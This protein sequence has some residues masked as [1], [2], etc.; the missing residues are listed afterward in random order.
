[1]PAR[2]TGTVTF[3][4]TDVE[5]STRR[6]EAHPAAMKAAMERHDALL[7]EAIEGHGGVVF[8]TMGDAFCAAF[9]LA[10]DAL[11]AA[12]AAQRALAVEM[13]PLEVGELR[14]R[15]ALHA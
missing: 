5:G 15:M 9:P 13:W 2:P 11:A 8:R 4:Y 3:L 14:V 1:M 7:R 12:L 10:Q 6:W